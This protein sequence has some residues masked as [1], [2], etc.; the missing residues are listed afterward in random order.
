MY[1]PRQVL[2]HTSGSREVDA[3]LIV[4]QRRGARGMLKD[5]DDLPDFEALRKRSES[6]NNE[7][8]VL[9]ICE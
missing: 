3:D 5:R 8:E 4:E 6:H 2:Y 1:D 7:L 9:Q